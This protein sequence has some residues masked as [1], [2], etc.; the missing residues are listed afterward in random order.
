M[1]WIRRVDVF[2]PSLSRNENSVHLSKHNLY[3]NLLVRGRGRIVRSTHG[4]LRMRGAFSRREANARLLTII[5]HK[6]I[7]LQQVANRVEPAV[8]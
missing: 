1:V 3:T 7:L 5:L 8:E 4:N 2:T 6:K